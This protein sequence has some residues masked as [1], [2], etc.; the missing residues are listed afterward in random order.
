MKRALCWIRRDLRLEDHTALWYATEHAEEVSVVFVFDSKI[1]EKLEDRDDRRVVFIHRSLTE[2]DQKLR[3]QGSALIVVHGDPLEEIPRIAKELG[4]DGVVTARDYEPYAVRRDFEASKK[5]T[6]AGAE[7]V[8]VKDSVVMEKGEVLSL[9]GT[10]FRV[11]SPYARAWRK[12]MRAGVDAAEY[13]PKLDKLMS[14]HVLEPVL[15]TYSLE[16]IGFKDSTLW[17]EA[18]EDAAKE[19]LEAFIPKVDAYAEDRNLPAKEGTSGLSVHLRFGTISVRELVRRALERGSDGADKWLSEVIWRDFYQDILAN[20]PRVT[21]TTFDPTFK[22]IEYPGTDEHFEAWCHGQTGYPLIDAAM[23]C[24][25]ATGWMH[26]RLRM[27]VASFLTK[28]LLV[29]YKKGEAYFARYLLDF[30]LASNN[31]G[32]QWAA[33]TGCDPQP[34]FR[35]F[36]PTLQSEKF[37]PEGEFIKKWIPELAKLPKRAVHA[38]SRLTENELRIAGVELGKNY[39]APIVQHDEMRPKA[40]ELLAAERKK[41]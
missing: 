12:A 13:S 39:P 16:E 18:G 21:Q 11:F 25:N 7:L 15:K 14:K 5:L 8:T 22:D 20:N 10:S 3:K 6:A 28:D 9:T 1:L 31:G 23:R 41:G 2:I 35:I 33:S 40:I 32:W 26:N 17:L 27:V 24:F 4:C 36:N 29:D 37:D 34:Y 30:D 19:R 38:P